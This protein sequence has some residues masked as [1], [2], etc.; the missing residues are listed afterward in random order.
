MKP[1]LT[2]TE[3]HSEVIWNHTVLPA[4]QQKRTHR[5]P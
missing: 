4:T 5:P 3:C 1:S 2:A